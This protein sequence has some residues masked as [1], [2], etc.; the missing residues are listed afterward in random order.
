MS[1]IEQWRRRH[2]AEDQDQGTDQDHGGE[3]MT[4][5]FRVPDTDFDGVAV[6]IAVHW[7]L[8]RLRERPSPGNDASG[9]T[10]YS[11]LRTVHARYMQAIGHPD[12]ELPDVETALTR[13]D[14]LP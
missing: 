2:A 14:V 5:T 6:E 9:K 4:L 1:W 3:E 12:W 13:E 8:A 10:A 7:V 11:V